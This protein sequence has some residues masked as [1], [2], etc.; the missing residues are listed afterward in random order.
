MGT[1][2]TE[3]DME[4]HLRPLTAGTW[5]A[6]MLIGISLVSSTALAEARP[7]SGDKGTWDKACQKSANCMPFGDVGGGL[8]GYF[9]HDGNG[10][11]TAVW[12]NDT[13]C[14]AERQSK[15]GKDAVQV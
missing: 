14:A 7:V 10:G 9:V 13:R 1:V 6:G 4:W 2:T 8:N 3:C 5:A 11:G 15:P 12:C